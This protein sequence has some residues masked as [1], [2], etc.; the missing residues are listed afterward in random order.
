M[1]VT[2]LRKAP[3]TRRFTIRRRAQSGWEVVDESDSGIA[4]RTVYDDWHRVERAIAI[5]ER[6]EAELREAGWVKTP[7]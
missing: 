4:R 7:A 6:E 5:F 1:Y 2:S 3:H